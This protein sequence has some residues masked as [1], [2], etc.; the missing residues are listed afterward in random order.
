MENLRKK[1][2]LGTV[3]HSPARGKI[4]FSKN[5]LILISSYGKVTRLIKKTNQNYMKIVNKYKSSNSLYEISNHQFL[6]PGFI[7]LHIHAP[8]WPQLGKAL[9]VPLESWL[10]KYTYISIG[11]KI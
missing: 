1:A 2:I 4:E 8:Q 7:D 10:Q 5:A 3:I 11:G 6:I 9:D